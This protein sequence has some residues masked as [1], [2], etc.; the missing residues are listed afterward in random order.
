MSGCDIDYNN[1]YTPG[2]ALGRYSGTSY[3]DLNAWG[4]AIGGDANSTTNDPFFET[5]TELR[6]YQRYVNGAGVPVGDVLLDIDGEIRNDAAPDM[7]A[8]EFIADFGITRLI[9]P[10]LQCDLTSDEPVTVNIRQFGDIPFKDLIVAYQINGDVI[11]YDT[12]PGSINNDIEHSF[13]GTE[14]LSLD[15]VYSFKIWLANANDDNN[16]NDTLNVE[17][18]KKPSPFVDF[19]FVTACAQENVQFNGT[20]SVTPGSIDRYEWDFGDSIYSDLQNPTHI[21]ELSETYT[22][23]FKAYS[24]EGCY[25]ESIQDIT[26]TTTPM[27]DFSA[28]AI[29]FGDEM[30]FVNTTSVQEGTLTYNWD[31]GDGD[32]STE[33]SPTHLYTSSGKFLVELEATAE[34]GCSAS[35]RDTV[36][37]FDPITVDLTTSLDT[38]WVEIT[39]G[40]APFDILWEDGSTGAM[41]TD[42]D[43]GWHSVTVTDSKNCSV[44]DSIEVIIPELQFTI[45]GIDAACGTCPDGSASVVVTQGVAPFY[46][47]WSNGSTADTAANL[48][49]GMHYVTVRDAYLN[50]VDDSIFI[51][52][53]N[54]LTISLAPTHLSCFTSDDGSIDLNIIGGQSPYTILWTNGASSEDIINLSAGSYSVTVTDAN[55]IS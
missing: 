17:R 16:L 49:P 37:M 28:E 29:C 42:L 22:V 44:I 35:K 40:I 7:G 13:P 26:L 33:E 6:P 10:T 19:S 53:S 4:A 12:I 51:D 39:G 32:N 24:N 8:D 20:A 1:Y 15:G 23:N 25:S 11:N 3:T 36:E 9:S 45:S 46:Y 21:Y 27:V 43:R 14:D 55:A 54:T 31:F 34:S 30:E 18:Y 38:V 47:Q 52:G 48:L 41:I 5:D 2:T 50:A